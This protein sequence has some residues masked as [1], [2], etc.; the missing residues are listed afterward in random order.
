MLDR[1]DTACP[2]QQP[3]AQQAHTIGVGQPEATRQSV[4]IFP[5]CDY[6]PMAREA[7]DL[8][9]SGASARD[10]LAA[11]RTRLW[12]PDADVVLFDEAVRC[13]EQGAH[14]AAL[15]MIWLAI[16]EGPGTGSRWRRSSHENSEQQ[17]W[18][19]PGS[20]CP[21]LSPP[22][23]RALSGRHACRIEAG[24]GQM[25]A[26]PVGAAVAGSPT[27]T[28]RGPII[29]RRPRGR[30]TCCAISGRE[31]RSRRGADRASPGPPSRPDR[32][33]GGARAACP[34]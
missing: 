12:Y 14:R 1:D 9:V 2:V 11:L 32:R 6:V 33:P 25:C 28:P 5:V 15:V 16:A 34:L 23:A 13:F 21:T 20:R 17:A 26:L 7:I 4:R 30:P 18:S 27:C 10:D 29:G 8:T 3:S 31:G 22:P 19:W 24:T